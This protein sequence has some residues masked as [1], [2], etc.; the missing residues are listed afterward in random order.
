MGLASDHAAN[1]SLCAAQ[2]DKFWE[3]K[4][5]LYSVQNQNNAYTEASLSRSF[6][7]LSDSTIEQAKA[8]DN[9][10]DSLQLKLDKAIYYDLSLDESIKRISGRQ[11]DSRNNT[12]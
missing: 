12:S 5:A 10:L 11:S 3:Y 8:F 7:N 9:V 6:S 1:A 4:D 2:Q